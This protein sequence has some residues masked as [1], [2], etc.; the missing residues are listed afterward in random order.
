MRSIQLGHLRRAYESV[1]RFYGERA[2]TSAFSD[3]GSAGF[4]FVIAP[5]LR[6][7][8]EVNFSDGVIAVGLAYGDMSWP[9]MSVESV[10]HEPTRCGGEPS[11]Q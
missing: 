5:G 2:E 1:N 3:G 4:V 10:P 8:L 6:V 11:P 7:S 9:L